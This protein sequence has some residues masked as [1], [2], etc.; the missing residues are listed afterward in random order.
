LGAVIALIAIEGAG[1]IGESSGGAGWKL[2]L[3][4]PLQTLASLL[5]CPGWRSVILGASAFRRSFDRLHPTAI[6]VL[7]PRRMSAVRSSAS[8]SLV[9]QGVRGVAAQ[10]SF[11][12]LLLS[13][14]RSTLRS[15]GAS[16][17]LFSRQR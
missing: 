7:L 6:I 16:C 2:V 4:V 14:S 11:V 3:L 12:E 9:Q 8:G 17:G 10:A 13:S 1:A 5:R 15:I